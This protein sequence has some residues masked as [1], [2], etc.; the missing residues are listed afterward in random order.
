METQILPKS[1]NCL[2]H[3]FA[4]L[5]SL[6]NL[7]G[8]TIAKWKHIEIRETIG[9]GNGVFPKSG[10]S[11][12]LKAGY[13]IPMN[14]KAVPTEKYDKWKKKGKLNDNSNYLVK[15]KDDLFDGDPTHLNVHP[16]LVIGSIVNEITE[17]SAE[18]YNSRIY[19][20]DGEELKNWEDSAIS[21]YHGPAEGLGKRAFIQIMK[22]I[23]D[24]NQEITCWYG[25]DYSRQNYSAKECKYPFETIDGWGGK[26][27][28]TK[29]K[30]YIIDERALEEIQMCEELKKG[31]RHSAKLT[32]EEKDKKGLNMRKLKKEK[33]IMLKKRQM[34]MG[35]I[36]SGRN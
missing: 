21:T 4:S 7:N 34:Q 19:I 16:S 13:M 10:C 3:Q 22:E 6:S 28:E 8:M 36:K 24:D 35:K 12:Y 15:I 1:D 26:E 31:V 32:K 25:P 23:K 14:L 29:L 2:D 27:K 30:A 11:K 33:Q 9:K 18:N 5:Q 17:E 20:L